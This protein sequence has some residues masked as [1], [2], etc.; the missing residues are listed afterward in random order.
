MTAA[1]VRAQRPEPPPDTIDA[2]AENAT[3]DY[4]L[5]GE[6]AAESLASAP[7]TFHTDRYSTDATEYTDKYVTIIYVLPSDAT[8]KGF[9]RPKMCT[10]G[11]I[12]AAPL[13]RTQ[14]NIAYYLR[15]SLSS[16]ASL[17]IRQRFHSKTFLSSNPLKNR[18]LPRIAWERDDIKSMS[19]Y[20]AMNYAEKL[21]RIKNLLQARGYDNKHGVYIAA[22]QAKN[23][24]SSILG[25]GA[26][27]TAVDAGCGSGT[28][29][30]CYGY[31][32]TVGRNGSGDFY[33]AKPGC[34][35]KWFDTI[36]A[37]EMT[38]IF[39]AV[40]TSAPNDD[41]N[42][43]MAASQTDLMEATTPQPLASNSTTRLVPYDTGADDYIPT[44]RHGWFTTESPPASEM[45][46]CT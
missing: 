8:D 11:T 10:N 23:V 17:D 28:A 4:L 9:D 44:I 31:T 38:H 21:T 45:I 27:F 43:H 18:V 34:A 13:Q 39:G 3:P 32:L 24:S 46:V 16:Q 7:C 6:S 36:L 5:W 2:A 20:N 41:G 12:Y 40:A 29:N 1:A 33:D 22:L 37:H 15:G 25:A 30:A 19:D 26:A 35:N 42:G 14:R